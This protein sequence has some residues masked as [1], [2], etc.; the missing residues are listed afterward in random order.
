MRWANECA[1]AAAEL[2]LLLLE[3]PLLNC[4]LNAASSREG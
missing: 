2:L 3:L 1:T 4:C